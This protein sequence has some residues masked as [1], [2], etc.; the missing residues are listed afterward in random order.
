[1]TSSNDFGEL[2][3]GVFPT[4]LKAPHADATTQPF[5]DAA[6]EDRLVMPRCTQCETFRLPPSPYCFACRH[7][8]TEWVELPGTGVVYSFTVVRHPLHPGLADACPY[9]TGVVDVDGTQGAG[10]RMLVNFID[11]D[12][13]ALKIGDRVEIVWEHLDDEMSVPRFRPVSKS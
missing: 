7:R 11:C 12:V 5:W 6:R 3:P 8:E 1:M 10:A 4:I 13:D 2:T 9:A